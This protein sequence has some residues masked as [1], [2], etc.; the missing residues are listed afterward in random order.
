MQCV[1]VDPRQYKA[2]LIRPHLLDVLQHNW[3]RRHW[4]ELQLLP[5]PR[6]RALSASPLTLNRLFLLQRI[7]SLRH[8]VD[9]GDSPRCLVHPLIKLSRLEVLLGSDLPLEVGLVLGCLV[10]LLALSQWLLVVFEG[11]RELV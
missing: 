1:F 11:V 10:E 4:V 6:I 2:I 7:L 5:C 3:Y 8:L 9:L